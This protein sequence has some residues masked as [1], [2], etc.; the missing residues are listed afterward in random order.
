MLALKLC[1]TRRV[2]HV[3]DL[4]ADPGAGLFAGLVALPKSTALTTY[5]YRLSH[6]RQRQL[7]QALDK[8]MAAAGLVEGADFD[9]DFHAVMHWDR[10][11]FEIVSVQHV[12]TAAQH[13]NSGHTA[14]RWTKH[15]GTLG[16]I[17]LGAAVGNILALLSVNQITLANAL[18]TLGFGILGAF[19]V[20][21]H[22]GKDLR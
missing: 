19:L 1:A 22:I 6:E 8:A 15:L 20:A 21:L 3:E 5:S 16:G 13:L 17:F 11:R 7:L 2:S 4:A 9:L 10:A 12:R 14:N 18:L